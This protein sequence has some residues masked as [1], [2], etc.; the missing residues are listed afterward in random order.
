MRKLTLI[1]VLTL[2]ATIPAGAQAS[3]GAK[4]GSRDP[5]P[6]PPAN[7]G[8]APSASQASQL[9][10]CATEKDTGDTLY[11]VGN[12]QVQVASSSRSFQSGDSY[13]DLDP[14][15]PSYISWSSPVEVLAKVDDAQITLLKNAM[16]SAIESQSYQKGYPIITMQ[17]DFQMQALLMLGDNTQGISGA[18]SDLLHMAGID[19]GVA[20]STSAPG[21]GS[22]VIELRQGHAV[23]W[24]G[25]VQI[26]LLPDADANTI[27]Q[28]LQKAVA[29]L[30]LT[31]P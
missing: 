24:R 28:R 16:Q 21:K 13:N 29:E 10:T 3:S 7:F 20:G 17:G 9:F 19:P 27:A 12:V 1:A 18:Q 25:A 4:Y 31:W 23:R 14:H 11:L 6:C 30:L 8:G 2:A 15:K 26:Y 22:L 5:K